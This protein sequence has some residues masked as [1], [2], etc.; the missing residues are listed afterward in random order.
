M[1]DGRRAV[2]RATLRTVRPGTL[3]D[4]Y[5]NPRA[6]V[7]KLTADGTMHRLAFGYYCEVPSDADPA[8][9]RPSLEAAAVAIATARGGTGEPVLMGLSAA[10]V[11]DALPRAIA[12][13]TVAV[14]DSGRRPIRL[15]DRAAIVRFVQRDTE[16]LDAER[17]VLDL[18]PA[19]VTTPEQTVLD[20]AR[21]HPGDPDTPA[22]LRALWPQVDEALLDRLARAG[23]G[24]ASLRRARGLLG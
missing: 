19:L 13:A 15:V 6:A 12:T 24:V 8:T 2:A 23:R 9:W 20:V 5:S 17:T 18:G 14:T 7:R 3:S 22:V 4:V 21:F 10:R 16:R 11:H 1:V